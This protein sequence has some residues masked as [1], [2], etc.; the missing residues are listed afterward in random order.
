MWYGLAGSLA[1]SALL[2]AL[3]GPYVLLYKVE[4]EV[5]DAA[6]T[7]LLAF[8]VLA[9]VKVANMIL[10]GG[11]VR[12]GGKTAYIMAIDRAGTWLVGAPLGLVTAFVFHLPVT[13]VYFILSQEELVRLALTFVMFRRRSWMERLPAG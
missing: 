7:L 12:S 8:A 3:R 1:L 10:G 4:P 13:W 5:R 9:P 2:M 11:I 6:G